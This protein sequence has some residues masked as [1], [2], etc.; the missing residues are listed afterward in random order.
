MSFKETHF[1]SNMIYLISLALL[2]LIITC[3]ICF[4]KLKTPCKI[5]ETYDNPFLEKSNRIREKKKKRK[6]AINSGHLVISDSTQAARTNN[7][8]N[9]TRP[10]NI[11]TPSCILFLTRCTIHLACT[12]VMQI[13][14]EILA[15]VLMV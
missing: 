14:E 2:S 8:S 13:S 1:D 4:L 10:P 12:L 11:P 5:L 15:R 9:Y 3:Q 7:A 6:N